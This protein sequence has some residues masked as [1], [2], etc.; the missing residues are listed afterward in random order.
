[1]WVITHSTLSQLHT[2]T[3]IPLDIAFIIRHTYVCMFVLDF[4]QTFSVFSQSSIIYN[5][6]EV[7]IGLD[8]VFSF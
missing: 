5:I 8:Y 2:Y 7:C 4:I 1:M 3:I 6:I